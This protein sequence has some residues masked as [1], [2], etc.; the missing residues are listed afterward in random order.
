MSQS[1]K[2]TPLASLLFDDVEKINH[3]Q[4]YWFQL[5]GTIRMC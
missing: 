3:D 2:E 4:D 5:R 1:K